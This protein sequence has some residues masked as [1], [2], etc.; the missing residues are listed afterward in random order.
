[1]LI[2]GELDAAYAPEQVQPLVMVRLR[3]R[4]ISPGRKL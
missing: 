3:P 1:V 2:T 4:K